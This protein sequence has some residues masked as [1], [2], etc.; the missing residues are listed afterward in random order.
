V[1]I[2]Y[3]VENQEKNHLELVGLRRGLAVCYA[4]DRGPL[5]EQSGNSDGTNAILLSSPEGTYLL[6]LNSFGVPAAGWSSW[7]GWVGCAQAIPAARFVSSHNAAIN[8]IMACSFL[9]GSLPTYLIGR[10]EL[11]NPAWTVDPLLHFARF[12]KACGTVLTTALSKSR[13]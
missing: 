3:S 12:A 9:S 11:P 13:G 6:K 8:R 1:R 2:D 4:P 5:K 7:L 10:L